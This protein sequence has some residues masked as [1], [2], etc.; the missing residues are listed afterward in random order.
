MPH[1]VIRANVK[2]L[3]QFH[4]RF[5][6]FECF[7]VAV[8]IDVSVRQFFI[9]AG[10]LINVVIDALLSHIG[11]AA[12]NALDNLLFSE[13]FQC[14]PHRDATDAKCLLQAGFRR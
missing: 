11:A 13:E 7:Y 3:S 1:F 5:D 9:K 4:I 14:L 12:L 6:H 10:K 8:G 2:R